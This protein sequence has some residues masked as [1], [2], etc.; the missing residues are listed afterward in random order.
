M[1]R[2]REE[3]DVTRL[4]ST[5]IG[6]GQ[7]WYLICSDWLR[8]WHAFKA[9]GEPPGPIT[10]D[11]LVLPDGTPRENLR[12]ALDYRGVNGDVWNYLFTIYGGGPVIQR[13]VIDVYARDP[14]LLT[15]SDS[16]SDSLAYFD[17]A[18]RK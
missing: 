16:K 8:R 6:D 18:E 13:E 17:A 5:K 2:A 1:K 7:V 9:G 10:N 4:D 15:S 3:G 12:K 11:R 14:N